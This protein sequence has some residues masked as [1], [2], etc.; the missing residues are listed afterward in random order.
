[1]LQQSPKYPV[2]Q[3]HML[4]ACSGV[5]QNVI[6]IHHYTLPVQVSEN[7]VYKGLDWKTDGTFINPYG[8]TRYS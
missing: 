2:H 4:S 6:D 1:M 7:L 3:G 8:T 5:Y